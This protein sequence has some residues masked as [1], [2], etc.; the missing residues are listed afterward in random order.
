[1]Q[2]SVTRSSTRRSFTT[3]FHMFICIVLCN[4]KKPLTFDLFISHS[5]GNSE[6][7]FNIYRAACTVLLWF[8]TAL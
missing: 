6:T 1:M 2:C 3:Y 7:Y 5:M 4:L 8:I